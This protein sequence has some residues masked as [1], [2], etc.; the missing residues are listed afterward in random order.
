[1]GPGPGNSYST[2]REHS[3]IVSPRHPPKYQF[4]RW[5]R[6]YPFISKALGQGKYFRYKEQG[7]RDN[8]LEGPG[9]HGDDGA[10][11]NEGITEERGREGEIR[12]AHLP[13][14]WASQ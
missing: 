8:L 7:E 2:N 10:T 3:A 1:M 12:A 5:I 6:T 13:V 9:G 14:K 4:T 11:V